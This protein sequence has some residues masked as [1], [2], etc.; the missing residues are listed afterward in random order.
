MVKTLKQRF[1][2]IDATFLFAVVFTILLSVGVI[3]LMVSYLFGEI[4]Q[5]ILYPYSNYPVIISSTADIL[6][7]PGSI[8]LWLG[9]FIGVLD[10]LS[11]LF[12]K[13]IYEKVKK[14]LGLAVG[15]MLV[16]SIVMLITNYVT[17]QIAARANGYTQCASGSKL[18]VGS[19]TSS[20]WSKEEYLCYDYNVDRL[21][22][23]GTH[24]QVLAVAE[25]LKRD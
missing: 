22:P 18:L 6:M 11:T 3:W 24:E 21:L 1:S 4:I 16:A 10:I 5:G 9:S 12:K 23:T 2:N 19:K 25:Y 15:V 13:P 7:I 8:V 17:W 14:K 20:V